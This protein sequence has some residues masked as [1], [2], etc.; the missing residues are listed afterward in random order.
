MKKPD[1]AAYSTPPREMAATAQPSSP[2]QHAYSDRTVDEIQASL[3]LVGLSQS[4][5]DGID[6]LKSALL[7]SADDNVL[8]LMARTSADNLAAET[9]TDNDRL[10]LRTMLAQMDAM[11]AKIRYL[12]G[13]DILPSSPPDLIIQGTTPISE[14]PGDM[15]GPEKVEQLA[16]LTEPTPPSTFDQADEGSMDLD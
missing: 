2:A 1:A 4:R 5:T 9:L 10:G 11:S 12:L 8:A 14:P 3:N 16:P 6:Q 15:D 13:E 7:T